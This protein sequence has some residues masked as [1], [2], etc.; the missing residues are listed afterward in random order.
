MREYIYSIVCVS[1]AIGIAC[2]ISPDGVGGGLKK[3]IK[4]VCALCFLCV[5][6]GPLIGALD[7]VKDTFEEIIGGFE[8]DD[9]E[10]RE[11]YDRIYNEY[12]EDGCGEKVEQVVKEILS[13]ELGIS[14]KNVRSTVQ[15]EDKN[16][17]GAKE[18]GKITVILSGKE[19][20]CDPSEIKA[21]IAQ[22]FDCECICAI[23]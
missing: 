6:I 1:A 13:S 16:G 15:F 18:I 7:G 2:A 11:E 21:C 8:G 19:I 9:E 4:L 20:F 12:I 17:D 22:T 5:M 14:E 23:E 3:H 10:I